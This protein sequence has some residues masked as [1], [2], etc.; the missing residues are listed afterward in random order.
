[1]PLERILFLYVA[2]FLAVLSIFGFLDEMRRRSFETGQTD[3]QVFRCEK[4][5]LVYTDDP[6]VDRS[7][8]PHCGRTNEPF[9]F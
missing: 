7:R 4:C 3:D 6:D 8:C 1:M 5:A 2:G 9:R